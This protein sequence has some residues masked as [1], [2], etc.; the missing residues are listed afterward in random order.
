VPG[1]LTVPVSPHH[2]AMKGT[3]GHNPRCVALEGSVGASV[4]CTIYPQRPSACRE[5]AVHGQDGRDNPRCTEAR[6]AWGLP[7]VAPPNPLPDHADSPELPPL[8]A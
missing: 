3:L 8:A 7:P 6:L 5:F 2:L 4:R 1:D